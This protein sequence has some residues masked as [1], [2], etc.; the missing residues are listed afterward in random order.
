MA[1]PK[2]P[3]AGIAQIEKEVSPLLKQA[4]SISLKTEE[5][6]VAATEFVANVK[7]KLKSIETMQDFFV[8]P[9]QEQRKKSLEAMNEIKALFAP[10]LEPLEK[11]EKKIKR[12][13]ADYRLE[14]ERKARA[15]EERL[16]KIREKANEKREEKGQAPILEP[17]KTI[18]RADSTV[19]STAGKTTTKKVWKFE[20]QDESLLIKDQ[21]FIGELLSLAINKGLHEQTLRQMVRDGVREVKGVRIYEDLEVSVSTS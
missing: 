8:T 7:S 5:D 4:D 3:E 20:I 17:V 12:A 19:K 18:E 1:Q 9:H 21:A 15:E 2:T 11:A 16:A 13:I 10:Q 14:E 6:V